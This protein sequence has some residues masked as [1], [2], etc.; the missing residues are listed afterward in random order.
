MKGMLEGLSTIPR[1]PPFYENRKQ[2]RFDLV[3]PA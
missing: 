1:R 3:Q 2:V